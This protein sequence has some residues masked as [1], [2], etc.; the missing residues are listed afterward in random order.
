[1]NTYFVCG[2]LDVTDDEFAL[3]Y[4]PR[5]QA[6]VDEGACFVV[7]DA[8]GCDAMV[9]AYLAER[10]PRDRVRVFHMFTSPRFN[11]GNFPVVGGFESD[12]ARDAAM[13][14][15]STAD[16]GWVRP[17]REKSGTAKN[18]ARRSLHRKQDG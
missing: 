17:G 3:H 4:A 9:Q 11:V 15:A 12:S 10:V 18:L 5:L 16:I 6:A 8:R 13:T 7:G 1:M 14:A 2:H